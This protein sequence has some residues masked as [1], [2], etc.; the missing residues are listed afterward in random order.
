MGDLLDIVI[1]HTPAYNPK[2]NSVE[3]FH[4]DLKAAL[5]GIQT[6]KKV[7]WE[8]AL[9]LI[10]FV[11]RTT[12]NRQTGFSPYQIIFARVPHIPLAVIEAPPAAKESEVPLLDYM[13]RHRHKMESVQELRWEHRQQSVHHKWRYYRD[14]LH[15]YHKGQKVWLFTPPSG[16][17]VSRKLYRGYTGPW[18]IKGRINLTTY[19]LEPAEGWT[20]RASLVVSCDRLKPY[21]TPAERL[22][23]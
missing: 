3:R 13:R 12:V 2:S 9:P 16:E 14:K 23:L 10:L 8:E 17:G 7:D 6:E 1:T 21:F 19:E 15:T 22:S 11:T 20:W 5:R 4:R 18:T